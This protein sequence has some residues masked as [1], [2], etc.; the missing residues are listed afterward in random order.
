MGSWRWCTVPGTV[1][2]GEFPTWGSSTPQEVYPG[3]HSAR[4]SSDPQEMSAGHP[5]SPP[6]HAALCSLLPAWAALCSSLSFSQWVV[7]VAPNLSHDWANLYIFHGFHD[8]SLGADPPRLLWQVGPSLLH[9]LQFLPPQSYLQGVPCSPFLPLE[10]AEASLSSNCIGPEMSV[11][12]T[13]SH[14]RLCQLP[15]F[16]AGFLGRE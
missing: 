1:F 6:C 13:R 7:V 10:E 5:S 12:Q 15:T 8:L 2:L 11:I 4:G 3:L 9:A 14:L 16:Q